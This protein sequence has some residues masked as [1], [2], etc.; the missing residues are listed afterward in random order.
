MKQ[1]ITFFFLLVISNSSFAQKV[2][3]IGMNHVTVDGFTFVAT[4]NLPN[5]EVIFFTEN[6]YN[7]A[8][9]AFIDQTESVVKFTAT[10]AIT[11]GT[12]IFVKEISTDV[13]SVSCTGPS[14]CGTAIKTTGSGN[15]A[16]ATDGDGL[17]AYAET[18]G[19]E[20]PANGVATIYAVMY[21]G[22]GEVPTT[23]GGN[24]PANENP[25]SDF[26]SSIVVQ[27]FPA[28][29]PNRTEFTPTTLARTNVTKA[30][31]QNT[32]NYVHAQANA[33]LSTI[34]FTTP[35]IL[36]LQWL[37]VAGNLNDQKRAVLQWSVQESNVIHY[38]VQK[39][40]D[41]AQWNTI[42]II[43]SKGTGV[44][45]YFSSDNEAIQTTTYF[46]IKQIDLDG[47][48]SY[49]TIIKLNFNKSAFTISVYPNPLKDFINISVG[50]SLINTRVRL[51]S[52][53]SK[54]LQTKL[55]ET[56]FSQLFF[57]NYPSGI[58]LLKFE[59]GESQKIIKD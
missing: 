31:V 51:Y 19:D 53:T 14:T 17:Y 11:K 22:S 58:Y 29:Q 59:N 48:V 7:N 15:F 50:I 39:S 55:L 40:I 56:G 32:A 4:Q 20:N 26:P 5:G 18:A 46:R 27:G 54:L 2:A 8:G 12:V 13:F 6:E 21:T 43:N 38:E 44:N 45:D 49:S 47:K 3:I 36:P 16:L 30:M 41:I 57:K 37:S 52:A 33:D 35:T 24:L 10:S 25:L 28:A 23:N 9:N 42:E 1:F 34:V